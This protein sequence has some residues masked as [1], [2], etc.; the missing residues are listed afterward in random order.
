MELNKNPKREYDYQELWNVL[1]QTL[2][3]TIEYDENELDVDFGDKLY[4]LLDAT[5]V[6]LK[7]EEDE[8]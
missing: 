6:I 5:R 7:D 8:N 4:G 3:G 1:I 2:E